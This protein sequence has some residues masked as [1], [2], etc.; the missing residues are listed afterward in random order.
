MFPCEFKHVQMQKQLFIIFSFPDTR[1][2]KYDE[3]SSSVGNFRSKEHE[4]F[5]TYTGVV[6]FI[7]RQ[8]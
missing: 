8:Y 5:M 6:T 4:K 1:K 3:L 7:Y 2:F